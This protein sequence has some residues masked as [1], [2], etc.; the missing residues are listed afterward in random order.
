MQY[1]KYNTSRDLGQE[2][3][4]AEKAHVARCLNA[5]LTA[6][7]ANGTSPQAL[8]STSLRANITASCFKTFT[9]DTT[10]QIGCRR[11]G[12]GGP[13][14]M[15]C[16]K[17]NLVP[18][19][20]AKVSNSV[21]CGECARWTPSLQTLEFVAEELVQ[22]GSVLFFSF[23]RDKLALRTPLQGMRYA[24]AMTESIYE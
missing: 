10:N 24:N 20:A 3:I 13:G 19:F 23:T 4:A 17:A 8:N 12:L 1:D 14:S 2:E 21:R 22:A 11:N 18:R 16:Y 5:S 9:F 6:L 7:A 15:M